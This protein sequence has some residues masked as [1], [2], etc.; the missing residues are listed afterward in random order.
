MNELMISVVIPVYNVEKYLRRCLDSLCAQSYQNLE[1]ILINDGSSD[2]SGDICDEYCARDS[3]FRCLHQ[4]NAGVSRARNRGIELVTGDFVHFL[5]SDDYI[6]PDSYEYLLSQMQQ[7]GAHAIGFEYFVTYPD[8]EIRN[9][10]SEEHCG[11]RDTR[12]ALREHLF[13]HNNFLC[14]K[15]LPTA[16]VRDL[17]FREDIY[18]D[19]DTLFGFQAI[20]KIDKMVFVDRPLLHYVQSENS[21]CRGDFRPSQ[22]SALKVI[23][24]MEQA[25]GT[26]YP[27]LLMPWRATYLHLMI[28]LYGDMYLDKKDYSAEQKMLYDEYKTLY[29]RTDISARPLSERVK[30]RLFRAFPNVFCV[31]HKLVHH[32]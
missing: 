18:R 15:L 30:F 4:E 16:A 26:D 27:E 3:R 25:L 1:I 14:T 12:G 28:M 6:E 23:P 9:R 17:R 7:A 29:R 5:D 11:L 31:A 2:S 8:R 19:E 13:S 10:R 21:A 24:I 32:L 22:L 20:Q